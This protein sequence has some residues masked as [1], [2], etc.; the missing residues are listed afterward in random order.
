MKDRD[1]LIARGILQLTHAMRKRNNAC[2]KAVGLTDEQTKSLIYL[3]DSQRKDMTIRDLKDYLL[4]S[5]QATQGIVK[6]M[7]DKGVISVKKSDRDGRE[8]IIAPTE[9]GIRIRQQLGGEAV[10]LAQQGE[11]QVGLFNLLVGVFQGN[12]LRALDGFQGFLRILLCVHRLHF[13]F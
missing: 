10:L 11:E 3:V 4:V 9:K 13:L 1:Y 6:R 5:H 12:V 8:K 7:A 2:L